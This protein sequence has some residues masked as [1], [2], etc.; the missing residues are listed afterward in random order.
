MCVMKCVDE[1]VVSSCYWV[2]IPAPLPS[3]SPGLLFMHMLVHVLSVIVC[4]GIFVISFRHPNFMSLQK[5]A[6]GGN[7]EMGPFP[8][9]SLGTTI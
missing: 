9:C 1:S 4:S 5:A 3:L 8:P 6:K 2:S 7:K